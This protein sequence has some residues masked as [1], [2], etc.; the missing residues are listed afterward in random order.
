MSHVDDFILAGTREFLREITQKIQEKLDIS[1]L[2][3]NVFRFTGID[4]F[5]E[6]RIVISMEEYAKSL[7]KLEIIRGS[8][9]EELTETEL[10]IYKKYIGKL[11]WLV[12]NMR[13][14]LAVYVIKSAK[15]QKKATLKE[16]RNNNRIL[17]EVVE[18]QNRAVFERVADK[19]KKCV[20]SVSDVSYH[21]TELSV[22]G[23]M[24]MIKK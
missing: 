9:E 7:E 2:E 24:T 23:E 15:K 3:D 21:Q 22:A 11:K 12:S 4:V 19:G 10:R 1:K 6:D 14:D 17:E 16:L 13:P 20:I 8:S 5:K 18:E